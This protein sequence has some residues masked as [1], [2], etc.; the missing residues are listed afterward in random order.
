MSKSKKKKEA[1]RKA[2]RKKNIITITVSVAVVAVITAAILLI[3]SIESR[4][5]LER[6]F[7]RGGATVTLYDEGDFAA[8]LWHGDIRIGTYSEREENGAS[9][10]TFEYNGSS[11]VGRIVGNVLHIPEPWDDIHWH[12]TEF[13]LRN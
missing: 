13:L 8:L 3:I 12:G 11:A 4:E 6:V 5:A 7:A 10:V 1:L 9:V 2:K